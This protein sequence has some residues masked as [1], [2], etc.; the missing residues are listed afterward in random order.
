LQ[1]GIW[2]VNQKIGG[3]GILN[4]KLQNE[5]LL[6]KYLHK[7]Y[8]KA[9]IPWV[10]LLWNSYYNG[11]VPHA[12]GPVGSFWWKDVCKLMPIFRGFANS[13]IKTGSSTLFW[14]DLWLSQ[15]TSDQFPRAFSF[16][17]EEDISVQQFLN[18]DNL[19]ANFYLPLSPQALAEVQ[20]L[21]HLAQD[22]ELSEGTDD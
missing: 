3:L 10:H 21:Q 14:K 1:L 4:L 6:L 13:N 12:V 17:T 7:F 20:Q 9:D 19:A 18:A 15:I 22:I 8:N 5:A 2:C 11:R 16:A